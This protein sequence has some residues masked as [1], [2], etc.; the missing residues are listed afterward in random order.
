M[1]VDDDAKLISKCAC[2]VADFT[3][4]TLPHTGHAMGFWHE[5]NRPDRDNYV[6]I[7]W[8]NMPKSE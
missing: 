4:V 2:F 3:I 5:Q 6:E 7:L 8:D 1:V